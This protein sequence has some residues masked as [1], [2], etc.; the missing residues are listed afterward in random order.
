MPPFL[1]LSLETILVRIMLPVYLQEYVLKRVGGQK[2]A[3][4]AITCGMKHD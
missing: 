1:S 3:K 4:V 2:L